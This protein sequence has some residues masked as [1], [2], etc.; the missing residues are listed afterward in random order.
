MPPVVRV[1]PEQRCAVMLLYDRGLAVLPLGAH[2]QHVVGVED[3]DDALTLELSGAA[4]SVAHLRPPT[5]T[6]ILNL[7]DLVR[8]TR[9]HTRTR[10]RTRAHLAHLTREHILC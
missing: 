5:D 8:C 2:R 1:D 3:D 10:T 7:A 4:A 9:T 6:W